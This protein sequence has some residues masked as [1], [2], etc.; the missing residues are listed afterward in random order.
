MFDMK[1]EF[2]KTEKINHYKQVA[3]SLYLT[4]IAVQNYNLNTK[5]VFKKGKYGK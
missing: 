1:K 5:K 2:E 4:N 3:K